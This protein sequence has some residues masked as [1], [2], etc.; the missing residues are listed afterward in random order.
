MKLQEVLGFKKTGNQYDSAIRACYLLFYAAGFLIFIAVGLQHMTLKTWLL[1]FFGAVFGATVYGTIV[2]MIIGMVRK[3]RV[4]SRSDILIRLFYLVFFSIAV[5][6]FLTLGLQ[7]HNVKSWAIAFIGSFGAALVYSL[8]ARL[9][10]TL[11]RKD[12]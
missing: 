1:G 3:D 5:V 10:I 12:K 9:I 6:V 2:K 4:K 7:Y 8:I 11:A